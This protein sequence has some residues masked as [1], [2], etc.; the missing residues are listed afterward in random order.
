MWVGE[1][2]VGSGVDLSEKRGK[3][4]H[5]RKVINQARGKDEGR[6]HGKKTVDS[7]GKQ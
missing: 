3:T 7:W 4:I 1:L 6:G 5:S 2:W